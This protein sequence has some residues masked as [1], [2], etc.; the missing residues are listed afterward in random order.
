M[1]R[2]IL[3][4]LSVQLILAAVLALGCIEK[5]AQAA[6]PVYDVKAILATPLNPK[7]TKKTVTNGI[8]TEEVTFHSEMDGEKSVDI[9]AFFSY[10]E[11]GK[12]LPAFVWNQGGLYQASSYWTEFGARRGYAALCIDFPLPGYRSTGGYNITSNIALDYTDPR[13]HPIYHGAVALLKAVSYLESRTDVVNKTRIGMCGSSWGGF[14]TTYMVGLDPRL[15]AGSA[16]FGCGSLQL[17]C[18]WFEGKPKDAE[19]GKKWAATLDPAFRLTQTKTPMHWC[20][21]TND[22][23]YWMPALMDS[24]QRAGGAKH[25]ALLPN[26]DHALSPNLDDEIFAFLDV[27]LKDA[28]PLN[29]V[30]PITVKKVGNN[31]VAQWNVSGPRKVKSVELYLSPGDDGNWRSRPWAMLPADLVNSGAGLTCGVKLPASSIPYYI[32][33]T[34]IDEN[35]YKTSTPLLRVDP[36]A[37]KLADNTAIPA[38]DGCREWGDFEELATK[39]PEDYAKWGDADKAQSTKGY[40]PLHGY[41]CPP[42]SPDAHTGKQAAVIQG[43]MTMPPARF[44]AGVPQQI[45]CWMKAEKPAEVTVTFTET[46]DKQKYDAKKTFT[47]GAEWAQYTLD[48]LPIAGYD[49]AA[50]LTFAAPKDVKVLL[51]TV[52]LKPAK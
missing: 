23:F 24:Y 38:V 50:T 28:P 9:F 43:S 17:G 51:D 33:G 35:A 46:A 14:Y 20:A 32:I 5:P 52:T 18:S 4:L 49:T 30:T 36:A 12:N 47:V 2:S 44:I 48:I 15:K 1:K 42:L 11:G 3:V 31:L 26:W 41:G 13:Q 29:A 37:F 40:I 10:P 16:M 25:L 6:D 22:N 19:Q 7:T 45:N 34:V 8:V 27:Y 39:M 21:T